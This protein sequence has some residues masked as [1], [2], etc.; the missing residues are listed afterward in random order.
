[1]AV[2]EDAIFES[3]TLVANQ[4]S[5]LVANF[6]KSLFCGGIPSAEYHKEL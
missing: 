2:A 5:R 4:L 3:I 1:M 6:V